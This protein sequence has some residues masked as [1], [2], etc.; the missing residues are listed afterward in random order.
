MKAP[1]GSASIRTWI[2]HK[3]QLNFSFNNDTSPRHYQQLPA[4]KWKGYFASLAFLFQH[5]AALQKKKSR[6]YLPI[7][8]MLLP[9][10]GH[11]K[12]IVDRNTG[13]LIY[14]FTLQ[15]GRLFH[16]TRKVSLTER[17]QRYSEGQ[18]V[19][20]KQWWHKVLRGENEDST[21]EQP[22]VKAPGTAK[23]TPVLPLK[24]WSIATLFP[25]SPSWTST[26]GSFWPTCWNS[27]SIF[28]YNKNSADI[29]FIPKVKS[30]EETHNLHVKHR[31]KHSYYLWLCL[32]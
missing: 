30:T 21:L 24:S 6:S 13:D 29:T 3:A 15:F 11:D 18:T 5:G 17:E 1:V 9:P 12:Y 22:G 4:F 16:K 19:I 28:K 31:R 7:G 10:G 20:V 26:A 27:N 8:S 14:A 32:P 23:R 2:Q 25:G